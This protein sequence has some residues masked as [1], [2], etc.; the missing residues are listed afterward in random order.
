MEHEE[1]LATLPKKRREAVAK[2]F[3]FYYT[4]KPCKRGHYSKRKVK[5]TC[6]ACYEEDREKELKRKRLA[7]HANKEVILEKNKKWRDRNKEYL[8]DKARNYRAVNKEQISERSKNRYKEDRAFRERC[9]QRASEWS[10]KNPEKT[11]IRNREWEKRNPHKCTAKAS[12]RRAEKAKR[13]LSFE[14]GSDLFYINKEAI[15]KI[16]S[17]RLRIQKELGEVMHVD[18]IVPLR[19]KKVSGLHVWYNLQILSGKENDRKGNKFTPYC[20]VHADIT[21]TKFEVT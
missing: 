15:E 9:K 2:G 10:T 12:R 21:A 20:E 7:Y 8:L 4:G 18:H 19:G 3:K 14:V 13:T 1:D 5:G 6:L 16:Y 17:D 11:R